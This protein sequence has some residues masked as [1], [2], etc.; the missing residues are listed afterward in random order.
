MSGIAE[1]VYADYNDHVTKGQVLIVLNTD[2]LKLDEEKQRAAV[3]KARATLDLDYLNYANQLKLADKGLISDYEVKQAKTTL[4]V[5]QADFVSE[6]AALKVIQTEINQYAFIKSPI[7]GV[8]LSRSVDV[9]QS[10][11]E[12]SSSNASALFT[13]A[14]DLTKMEIEATVDEVDIASINK[15]QAVRFTVEALP[16]KTFAG[17]VETIRLVPTTTDNVVT[18]TVIIEVENADGTLLPGMTADVDFIVSKTENALMVPN[19][20]LRY[21]P[22]TLTAEEIAD[23]TFQAELSLLSPDERAKAIAAKEKKGSASTTGAKKTTGLTSLMM[24]GGARGPGGPGG[25]GRSG[26]S[27]K[28]GARSAVGNGVG[29]T[30]LQ[31][32]KAETKNVWYLDDRGALAVMKVTVGVSDGTNTEIVPSGELEGMKVIVKEKV[33]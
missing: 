17:K 29:G 30:G 3:A 15:G 25:F 24:G 33:N 26:T 8:V 23:K 5:A 20:A 32:A 16:G 12:G 10:V 27:S 4:D 6:N 22:S 7:T 1:K 21:E 18:Y 19:A 9:G 14:E 28:N 31:P 13:I 11:V 2:M